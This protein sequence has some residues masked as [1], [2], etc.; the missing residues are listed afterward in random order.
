[1]LHIGHMEYLLS[2]KAQCEYLLIGISNPDISLTKYSESNPHRS[3]A[4]SNPLTY[5]ERFQMIKG[6]MIGAGVKRNE[7]DV[8][9]FPINRPDLLLNYVP[10][11]AKFYITV[12]DEWGIDKRKT[13]V[14]LGCNVDVTAIEEGDKPT[15]GSFV[16]DCIR[17]GKPWNHL[18]PK[19]VYDYIT[20]SGLDERI[21]EMHSPKDGV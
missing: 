1:M 18:V 2:G 8:V 21:R 12:Y 5:F 15:S 19:Y 10:G 9:P 4:I 20:S 6:A 3:S 7:F 14:S 16:R 13:L 11:N 17:R